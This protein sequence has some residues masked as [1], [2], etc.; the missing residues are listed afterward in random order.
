MDSIT[1]YLE[2]ILDTN[3]YINALTLSGIPKGPLAKMT[4]R[5]KTPNLSPFQTFH[6]QNHPFPNC[7]YMLIN[8]NNNNN[9]TNWMTEEDIPFL[10]SYLQTNNYIIETSLTELL[11]KA[12]NRKKIICIFSYNNK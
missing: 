12:S 5:I 4:K 7:V 2:P 6:N 9:N 8:H 11:I 3:V 1:L 10:F